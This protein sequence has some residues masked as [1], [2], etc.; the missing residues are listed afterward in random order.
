[1]RP[2]IL[3]FALA[4]SAC[5]GFPGRSGSLYADL[6]GKTGIEAFVGDAVDLYAADARIAHF[7]QGQDLQA[8]KEKVSAQLCSLSGGPCEYAGRDMKTA[9]AN[10][11]VSEADFNAFVED[12]RRAMDGRAVPLTAQNRLLAL[13]A[14]MRRDI[15]GGQ[16]K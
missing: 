1:M 4:A 11:G 7:F 5:A 12:T 13:L 2:I 8:I 15:L 6:G 16:P 3:A 14:P 10:M 9:H